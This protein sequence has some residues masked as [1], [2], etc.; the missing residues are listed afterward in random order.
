MERQTTSIG[1]P[2]KPV[3]TLVSIVMVGKAVKTKLVVWGSATIT[4]SLPLPKNSSGVEAPTRE[5]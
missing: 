2:T 4:P 3:S 5:P 1:R